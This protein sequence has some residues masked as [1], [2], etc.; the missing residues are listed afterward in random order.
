MSASE[1]QIVVCQSN[2][3]SHAEY[4]KRTI[5]ELSARLCA[6]F[7]D[8]YSERNLR[9]F[10]AFYIVFP[11]REIWRTRVPNLSCYKV[12]VESACSGR[13][14]RRGRQAEG[15]IDDAIV[16]ERRAEMKALGKK[17]FAFAKMD[18]SAIPGVKKAVVAIGMSAIN[19]ESQQNY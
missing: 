5:T 19:L 7:G 13:A 2:A 14:K 10:R 9:D 3:T 15:D 6:E 16:R 17:C 18:A 4:G 11:N 8:G 12:Q 1:N